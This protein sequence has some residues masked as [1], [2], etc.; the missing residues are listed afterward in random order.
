MEETQE[1][2]DKPAVT[3]SGGITLG[4]PGAGAPAEDTTEAGQ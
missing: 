4:K 3:G 2:Q 1:P